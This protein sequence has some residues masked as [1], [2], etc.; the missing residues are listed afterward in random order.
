MR[1]VL[2]RRAVPHHLY[3]TNL[4]QDHPTNQVWWGLLLY[5]RIVPELDSTAI[6]S[7]VTAASRCC[8][9]VTTGVSRA[10]IQVSSECRD[11][12]LGS[13]SWNHKQPRQ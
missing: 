9:A 11:R 12:F 8:N 6:G 10:V 1:G 4:S 2:P 7:P 5:S 3:T 13:F